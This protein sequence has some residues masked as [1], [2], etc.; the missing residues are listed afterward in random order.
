MKKTALNALKSYGIGLGLFILT[1]VVLL[2]GIS[3]TETASAEEQMQ[4]LRDNI[5]RAVVSCYAL[6]GSYP[7]SLDYI[8]EHYNVR[9][10][11]EK[12]VVHYMIFASNIMP[13]VDIMER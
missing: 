5:N 7:E 12:F 9:I 6:E 11:D 3:S 2:G 8:R 4:M 10:D 13:D 1:A